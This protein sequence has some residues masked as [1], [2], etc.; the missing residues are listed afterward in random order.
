MIDEPST[1]PKTESK[2][3]KEPDEVVVEKIRV[4]EQ[5]KASSPVEEAGKLKVD[6][7]FPEEKQSKPETSEAV[8]K[9]SSNINFESQLED[10][11]PDVPEGLIH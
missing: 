1:V 3:D 9:E 10:D 11:S 6:T 5:D 7:L 2:R 8:D 4:E